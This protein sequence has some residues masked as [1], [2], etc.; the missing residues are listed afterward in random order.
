M[1]YTRPVRVKDFFGNIKIGLYL[2]PEVRIK[3]ILK[4]MSLCN[5]WYFKCENFTCK[6]GKIL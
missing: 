3:K 1:K 4:T 6:S 2:G 5:V